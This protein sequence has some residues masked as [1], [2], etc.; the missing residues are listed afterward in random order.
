MIDFIVVFSNLGNYFKYLGPQH[1]NGISKKV[2]EFS[3]YRY[4]EKEMRLKEANFF[5]I[6][7]LI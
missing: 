2:K 6:I 4:I 7:T 3:R 5:M 1:Y